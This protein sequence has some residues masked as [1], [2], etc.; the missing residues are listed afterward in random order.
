MRQCPEVPWAWETRLQDFSPPEDLLSND[1]ISAVIQT[2]RSK[3][4]E[5]EM[6]CVSPI[7][8]LAIE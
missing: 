6:D 5:N 8:D 7:L 3:D 2:Y 4:S 1:R